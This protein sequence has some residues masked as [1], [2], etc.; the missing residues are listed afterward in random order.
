VQDISAFEKIKL[1]AIEGQILSAEVLGGQSCKFTQDE[2]GI[3]VSLPKNM[4][5]KTVTVVKLVL[6]RSIQKPEDADIYFTG[7]E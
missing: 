6:D 7:K 3:S 5:S 2:S 1:P 4:P